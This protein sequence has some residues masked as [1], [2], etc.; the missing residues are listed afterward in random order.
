[1]ALVR[2]DIT[3]LNRSGESGP[4]CLV[5]HLRG[6]A[7]NLPLLSMM[8]AVGL[9]H[10]AFIMLKYIPLPNFLSLFIIKEVAFCQML[11]LHL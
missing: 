1:M 3:V 2:T 5:F 9:S 4:L 11:L 10:M 6:K 7:F 8:L